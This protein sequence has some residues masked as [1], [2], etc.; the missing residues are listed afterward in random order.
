MP[1]PLT[2]KPSCAS[3][4]RR[5]AS[6][7]CTS[8][9]RGSRHSN[10]PA[11][12]TTSGE[13]QIGVDGCLRVSCSRR[14]RTFSDSVSRHTRFIC[15][16]PFCPHMPHAALSPCVALA[17]SLGSFPTDIHPG[18]QFGRGITIDHGTGLVVGETVLF[19]FV[20]S[21]FFAL[22]LTQCLPIRHTPILSIYISPGSI[23]KGDP[24]RSCLHDA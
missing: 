9:T 20:F 14:C 16:T 15:Q 12:P 18:A 6:W 3:T 1:L 4:L 19:F 13:D 7:V 8:S 17:H 2:W 11:S 5:R 22:S 24:W 23:R 10:A 21:V